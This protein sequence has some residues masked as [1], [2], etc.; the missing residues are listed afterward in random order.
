MYSSHV[1]ASSED[2]ARALAQEWCD[3]NGVL[4]AGAKVEPML[5]ARESTW[6][7]KDQPGAPVIPGSGNVEAESVAAMSTVLSEPVRGRR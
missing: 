2:I 3:R 4:L 7:W 5:V 6:K 1:E